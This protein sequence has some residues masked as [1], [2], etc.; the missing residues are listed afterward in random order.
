MNGSGR[1]LMLWGDVDELLDLPE[2]VLSLYEYNQSRFVSALVDNDRTSSPAE[3]AHVVD[4]PDIQSSGNGKSFTLAS[5]RPSK[6]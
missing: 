5:P 3:P 2:P 1:V 4:E 6:T